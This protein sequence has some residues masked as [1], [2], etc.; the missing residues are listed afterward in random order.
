MNIFRL[1]HSPISM[2]VCVFPFWVGCLVVGQWSVPRLWLSEGHFPF[3]V[4]MAPV[5]LI[6]FPCLPNSQS[7][8]S[9]SFAR[10]VSGGVPL[11][12]FSGFVDRGFSLSSVACSSAVLITA[13][14]SLNWLAS[15]QTILLSV[16]RLAV[17]REP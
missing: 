9:V 5:L 12:G 4:G 16:T 13:F 6:E 17:I 2:L 1:V 10:G 8:C 11:A 15:L 14:T 3:L 7:P